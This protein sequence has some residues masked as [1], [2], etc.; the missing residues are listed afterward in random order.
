LNLP[1][2]NIMESIKTYF[3]K[4]LEESNLDK[5]SIVRGTFIFGAITGVYILSLWS[6]CYVLRP[7]KYIV[8]YL[9]WNFLK[10][11]FYKGTQKAQQSKLLK[12]I[13]ESYRS[14]LSVSFGEMLM[15]KTLLGPAAL[16]FK[17]WLTI[18]VTIMTQ[19]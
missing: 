7:T 19:I 2:F 13:P 15:F 18:K 16:P 8:E 12:Y 6:L 4:K 17:I 9:Q 5:N 14:S 10:N 11:A 3:S 1:T